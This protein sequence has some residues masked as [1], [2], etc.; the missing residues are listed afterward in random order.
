MTITNY[1]DLIDLR[2][3]EA[4]IEEL[5]D[6]QVDRDLDDAELAERLSLRG[7]MAGDLDGWDP[8]DEPTLIRGSYFVEYAQEL[9]EDLGALNTIT[10]WPNRWIDWERAA[11]ELKTDYTAIDFDGVEYFIRS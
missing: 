9:A 5:K 4:R 10:S 2:D 1:D 7:L 11:D 8:E 3:V 6:V